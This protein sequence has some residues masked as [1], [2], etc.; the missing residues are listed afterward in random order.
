VAQ[1]A[2]S[3]SGLAASDPQAFIGFLGGQTGARTVSAFIG[4]VVGGFL[5]ALAALVADR[6]SRRR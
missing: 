5:G 6:R 1:L 4:A 2:A 3:S